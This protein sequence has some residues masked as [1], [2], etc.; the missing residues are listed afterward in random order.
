M[1]SVRNV[2]GQ[3]AQ[4]FDQLRVIDEHTLPVRMQAWNN[5]IETII[6]GAEWA[7]WSEPELGDSQK[8]KSRAIII[9]VYFGHRS[10]A[11]TNIPFHVPLTT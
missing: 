6:K 3:S 9:L 4:H 8:F 10:K 1:E 11:L 7:E 5:N 2:L